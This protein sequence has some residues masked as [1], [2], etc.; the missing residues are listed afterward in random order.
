MEEWD[1]ADLRYRATEGE[2]L[3]AGV[4]EPEALRSLADLRFV[5]R[6]LGGG[7]ALLTGLRPLLRGRRPENLLDVGC[8]SADLPA[9]LER[10]FPGLVT[11]GVDLKPLH[12]LQAPTGIRRVAA[13]VFSLPF[14]DRSFDL[15]TASLF[16]HHFEADQ[17]PAVLRALARVARRAVIVNDL[18]RSG[19]LHRFGR[20]GFPILFR[21]PVTV[22]DALISVR[23]GFTPSELRAG[24]AGAG[25]TRVELRRRWPARLV[26]IAHL[27]GRG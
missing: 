7:E 13:D 20:I 21:S 11:I 23:R 10:T 6:W 19:A 8:G 22:E 27:D 9:L 2:L 3:D 26:A 5:N 25:L 17:V 1:V 24:F 14:R 12:L 15:V 18:R 16:L 4:S